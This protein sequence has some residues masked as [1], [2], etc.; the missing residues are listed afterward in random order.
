MIDT[1]ELRSRVSGVVLRPTDD[2]YAAEV[3]GFNLAVEQAPDVVVGATSTADVV[4]AVLFARELA[5][6]VH[7]QSTGHG[8]HER[9]TEGVL[10]STRRMA[11]VKLDPA[12]RIATIGAG[13]RWSR[14]IAAG[15]PLGLAPIAGA[16]SSVG[17]V[18]YLTGGGFGPL[19]RSHGVS[20][21][22]VRGYTVVTGTG[23][24]VEASASSHSDLYWAL[25]GGKS[26][27]GIVT[28][29]R[30]ELVELPSLYAGSLLF[31]NQHIEKVLRGWLGY[32]ATAPEA[33]TTS[34]VMLRFPPIDAV[35]EPMRGKNFASVRFAY[36]GE[37]GEG[38]RLAAPLRALAPVFIDSLGELPIDEVGLI[39]NDPEGPSPAWS[40]GTL[41]SHGDA[42]LAA[43]VY[44]A[45]GPVARTPFVA[46]ELR[47]L[48]GAVAVDVAEGSA[49]GGR[50]AAYALTL[51]AAPEPSL[52]PKVVPEAAA[53]IF[54]AVRPWINAESNVNF[55]AYVGAGTPNWS[56][57]VTQRLASVRAKY[58]PD[59]VFAQH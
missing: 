4:E 58:D 39:H 14:V 17:V 2:G 13:T 25:R 45:A 12:S 19:A 57:A 42:A 18:G 32:T 20:S 26:G 9:I 53:T 30:F 49:V 28:E 47:H 21:D 1:A 31:E 50:S 29:V 48:G 7:V 24:V 44:A 23:D 46:A 15:A 40:N 5:L 27:L 22:Y 59:R 37:I 36:P 11:S 56:P 54:D 34:V 33:V 16:S 41:L 55:S 35:P 6:P 52:F 38:K 10:V 51:I 8:A 43:A 3:A